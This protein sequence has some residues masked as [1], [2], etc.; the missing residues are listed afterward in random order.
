MQLLRIMIA[1]AVG[2]AAARA[3]D[4]G[5]GMKA[6]ISG[7]SPSTIK[8]TL[9][10][11]T[12]KPL[13]FMMAP[14]YMTYK[15]TAVSR[16]GSQAPSTALAESLA[17]RT[18]VSGVGMAKVVVLQPGESVD[19]E[20]D[21]GLLV[22]LSEGIY[23]VKVSRPWYDGVR[24]WTLTTDVTVTIP[25]GYS[26]DPACTAEAR[27]KFATLIRSGPLRGEDAAGKSTELE[28][29]LARRV[30]TS[31]HGTHLLTGAFI[32]T[33]RG[34]RVAGGLSITNQ[35]PAGSPAVCVVLGESVRDTLAKMQAF[36]PSLLLDGAAPVVNMLD[37]RTSDFLETKIA[38][39]VLPSPLYALSDALI[40]L[41][42][43]PEVQR[44]RIELSL[45][46]QGA[47]RM[48]TAA[49]LRQMADRDGPLILENV[50]LRQGLN[51]ILQRLGAGIWFY[52]E[53]KSGPDRRVFTFGFSYRS[54]DVRK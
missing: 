36:D 3:E 29:E 5:L 25:K 13:N 51:S 9:T 39:V 37:A 8:F 46:E 1:F 47:S 27:A 10:N 42:D 17:H 32:D 28:A 45:E 44:R 26:S 33:L 48:P 4:P 2:L 7:V 41:F 35:G 23:Q 15:V 12:Q 40:T 21:V 54:S 30:E 14:T 49:I 52:S 31:S 11:H 22:T 38:K 53:S 19:Q 6:A 20:L 43:A 50:T 34:A 18:R 16:D 24:V